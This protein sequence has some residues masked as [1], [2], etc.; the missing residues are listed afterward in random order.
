M[1]HSDQCLFEGCVRAACRLLAVSSR[2]V[3]RCRVAARRVQRVRAQLARGPFVRPEY[4]FQIAHLKLQGATPTD[5]TRRLDYSHSSTPTP[6]FRFYGNVAH[7]R[8]S[9]RSSTAP[10]ILHP[11]CR[12]RH[13]E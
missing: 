12:R 9:S 3:G 6:T 4:P 10:F 13:N 7:L 2:E 11:E 5:M 1:A 8:R